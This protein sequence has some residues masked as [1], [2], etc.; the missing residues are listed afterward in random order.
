MLLAF[1]CFAATF[2][3]ARLLAASGPDEPLTLLVSVSPE[4]PSSDTAF[5]V[6]ILVDY[7]DPAGTS[8]RPPSFPSTIALDRT[9]TEPHLMRGTSGRDERWTAIEF[10]FTLRSEEDFVLGPFE[11]SVPGK[12]A[13]TEPMAIRVSPSQ[14]RQEG[15]GGGP[16]ATL[17]W[18]GVPA[19]I[20]AGEAAELTLALEGARAPKNAELSAEAPENALLE[21]LPPKGQDGE[22][23]IIGRFKLTALQAPSV[24]LPA[25][26]F[27]MGG[28]ILLRS[29]GGSIAVSAAAAREST[30]A[31]PERSPAAS[32][33]A[34]TEGESPK[35]QGELQFPE[36][37]GLP[38]PLRFSAE[39]TLSLARSAWGSG[40]RAIALA[41][42]R[43]A[44]RDSITGFALTEVRRGA[45]HS[46]G[47]ENAPNEPYAPTSALVFLAITSILLSIIAF[48][49]ARR[50]TSGGH[51]GYKVAILF[52]VLACVSLGRLLLV[53]LDAAG[54]LGRGISAIAPACIAYRIPE[55]EGGASARF[56]EGEA[57]RLRSSAG[58]WI[59]AEAADGRSGWV[60][61]LALIR[62]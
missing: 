45:E 44:E 62:Y 10:T 30:A 46:L 61:G 4:R 49:T 8:V 32:E 38:A 33:G 50:V 1:S 57:I 36:A 14:A 3:P 16:Q 42:L 51:R 23:G 2:F 34:E 28:G 17:V 55:K 27:S 59:Y 31:A 37:I 29:P 6:T 40:D 13:R 12:W 18:R 52:L 39:K 58:A 21:T 22:S 20:R 5:I 26:T 43:A 7:P 19:S 41:T 53:R 60:E 47:I 24:R 25:V 9:R 11:V 48:F 35:V 54:F 56:A 15:Q